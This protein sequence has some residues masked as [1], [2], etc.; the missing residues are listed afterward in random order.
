MLTDRRLIGSMNILKNFTALYRYG[1]AAIR[2]NKSKPQR[3]E[4]AQSADSF[5]WGLQNGYSYAGLLAHWF[6]T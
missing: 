6:K 5:L 2:L 1:I 4:S 3:K